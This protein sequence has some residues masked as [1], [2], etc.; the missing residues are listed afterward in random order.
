MFGVP[1]ADAQTV[2]KP[3]TWLVQRVKAGQRCKAL[4]P[5]IRKAGL[6]WVYFTYIAYR[7]SRCR[8][9]AVNARWDK[10]GR[11]VWTLNRNGTYD[12]GLFQINSSW[13]TVT[14]EECGGGID[15]L[16]QKKCNLKVAVRLFGEGNLRH[17]GF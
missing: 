4:E 9:N 10:R 16:L 1:T 7:E 3:P 2:P 13:R 12:S 15:R 5:D 6:P 14:R 17:W 8:E 11:I